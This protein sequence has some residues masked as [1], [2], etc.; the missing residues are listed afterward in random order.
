MSSSVDSDVAYVDYI[1]EEAQRFSH[2]FEPGFE[3]SFRPP[4]PPRSGDDYAFDYDYGFGDGFDDYDD[5]YDDD[6]SA[7]ASA[8]AAPPEKKKKKKKRKK[9]KRRE[10]SAAGNAAKRAKNDGAASAPVPEFKDMRTWKFAKHNPN[11]TKFR[12]KR[13]VGPLFVNRVDRP[14]S[15]SATVWGR[16]FLRFGGMTV[17][18]VLEDELGE[19]IHLYDHPVYGEGK[20]KLRPSTEPD[21]DADVDAA[22]ALHDKRVADEQRAEE[23]E[24]RL[25]SERQK[26]RRAQAR[27][28]GAQAA[29]ARAGKE[30]T[31]HVGDT[32]RW[33]HPIISHKFAYAQVMAMRDPTG[34]VPWN[35][36]LD[37][38]F[39]GFESGLLE[40]GTPVAIWRRRGSSETLQSRWMWAL[41]SYKLPSAYEEPLRESDAQR[42]MRETFARVNED[43]DNAVGEYMGGA[44]DGDLSDSEDSDAGAAARSSAAL[45]ELYP[46]LRL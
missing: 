6:A 23:E 10:E 32:I 44:R 19:Y 29:A 46:N 35:R 39:D 41:G 30:E 22:R 20:E 4:S 37:W 34:Q 26:R 31:L 27:V 7:A 25:Q 40:A 21:C 18:D 14:K 15:G 33:Q 24:R 36:R 3:P 5:Y 13:V 2:M 16:Q 38:D 12:S 1:V 28:D 17:E 42:R 45:E 8:A 9:K 43:I 11:A